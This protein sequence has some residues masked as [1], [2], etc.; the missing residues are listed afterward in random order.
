M[1]NALN[2]K[3]NAEKLP[4]EI[5]AGVAFDERHPPL[6]N[7]DR[8]LWV[9]TSALIKADPDE[10][11]E[12]WHDAESA[13]MWQ[14]QIVE[15]VKTGQNTSHWTMQSGNKTIEWDSEVLADEPG[16]RIA[17][18]AI[19]GESNNA[20][21]VIFE[22]APG[23]RGTMVTVSQEFKMSKIGS[24]WET[25]TGRNPGQAVVENLRHFKAFAET[26]EFLALR[27]SRMGP[28]EQQAA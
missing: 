20:G 28:A 11:Y 24:A 25:L 23:N 27:D 3:P 16:H 13:P 15:V 1:S 26:G 4:R 5:S 6:Q 9:R 10:L 2:E 18:K 12:L 14:E 22:T 7:K 21:E 17:W 19:G 8:K